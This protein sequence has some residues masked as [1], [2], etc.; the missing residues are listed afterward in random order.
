MLDSFLEASVNGNID[1]LIS[2]LEDDIILYS[3]SGG[4]AR[5][6]R[7]PIFG[8]MNVAKFIVNGLLG[9]KIYYGE[10]LFGRFL[11]STAI[12]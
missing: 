6:A 5:A 8:N 2:L 12:N 11:F 10:T 3:D 4:N 1:S 9:L 7:K